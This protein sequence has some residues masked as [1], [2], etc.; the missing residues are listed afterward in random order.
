[1]NQ[2]DAIMG[3][4]GQEGLFL[5]SRM[6]GITLK[7]ISKGISEPQFRKAA[8]QN[9]FSRASSNAKLTQSLART[10]ADFYLEQHAPSNLSSSQKR[11]VQLT[12]AI[13]E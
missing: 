13:G 1:M 3:Y 6:K 10:M 11:V 2:Y 5:M 9:S 4:N 12:M 8:E 7:E